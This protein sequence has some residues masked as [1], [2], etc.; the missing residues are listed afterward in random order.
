M[1]NI[2]KTLYLNNFVT[3]SDAIKN[4][5]DIKDEIDKDNPIYAP[6]V[7]TIIELNSMQSR[8]DEY[9]QE[10]GDTMPEKEEE[11]NIEIGVPPQCKQQNNAIPQ[12]EEPAKG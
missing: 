2:Y 11:E 9:I 7:T 1:E 6:L 5:E 8:S 3:V 12:S 4:L 10:F